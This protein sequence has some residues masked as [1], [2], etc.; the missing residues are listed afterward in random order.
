MWRVSAIAQLGFVVQNVKRARQNDRAMVM[1][2][3]QTNNVNASAV[4]RGWNLPIAN[5][6]VLNNRQI[7]GP[8]VISMQKNVVVHV[9]VAGLGYNAVHVKTVVLRAGCFNG[10]RKP[11]NAV[12]NV[13]MRHCVCMV[14]RWI[15]KHVNAGA[16]KN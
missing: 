7:V 16:M 4:H 12:L 15:P 10:M 5:N 11:A 14:A 1:A 6:V 2:F 3:G 13:K 9:T 8:K